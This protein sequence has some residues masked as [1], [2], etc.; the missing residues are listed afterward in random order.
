MFHI[1][2]E[3]T[4]IAAKLHYS[5]ASMPRL[6]SA[7]DCLQACLEMKIDPRE[8]C[9]DN[10]GVW[11]TIKLLTAAADGNAVFSFRGAASEQIVE[12]AVD[13]AAQSLR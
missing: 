12:E 3:R 2:Q 8:L 10:S 9:D 5:G 7:Q 4:T 6:L 1:L 13:A 11:E